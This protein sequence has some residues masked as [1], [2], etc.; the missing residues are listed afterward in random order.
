MDKK[1]R[2][3]TNS[4]LY[5]V[6]IIALIIWGYA[7]FKIFRNMYVGESTIQ[8]ESRIAEER[9]SYQ[10][11]QEQIKKN[12]ELVREFALTYQSYDSLSASDFKFILIDLDEKIDKLN[13]Q[14]L[15]LRQAIN[16]LNPDEVLT[17][18]RLKDV[19]NSVDQKQIKLE[20]DLEN[21]FEDFRNSVIRELET[22]NKVIGWLFIVFIP[23]IPAILSFLYIIWRDR[24]EL[25]LKELESGKST[26]TTLNN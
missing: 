13:E 26:S 6:L 1:I 12:L 5:I 3:I 14:T 22:L 10:E 2:S 7:M 17:I 24:K 8:L 21:R 11:I 15:S 4:F 23:L 18:A 25:K 9:K 16:P 19:I 20:T